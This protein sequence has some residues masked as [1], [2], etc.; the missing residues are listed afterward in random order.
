MTSRKQTYNE[1]TTKGQV[2]DN[3]WTFN[4]EQTRN[5]Q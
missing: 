5:G 4:N 2:M 3:K 1:M